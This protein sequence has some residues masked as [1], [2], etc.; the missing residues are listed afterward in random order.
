MVLPNRTWAKREWFYFYTTKNTEPP[1]G[2]IRGFYWRLS[3]EYCL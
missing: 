3:L 2:G 1:S